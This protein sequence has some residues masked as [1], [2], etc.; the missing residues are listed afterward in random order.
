MAGDL[1]KR[2]TEQGEREDRERRIGDTWLRLDQIVPKAIIPLKLV[3]P[4][5]TELPNSLPRDDDK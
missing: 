3:K 4:L 5:T 1:I 2:L